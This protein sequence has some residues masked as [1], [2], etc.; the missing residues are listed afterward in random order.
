MMG[1]K[2]LAFV[3]VGL[4]VSG[5]TVN[6]LAQR[7]PVKGGPGPKP[8][9]WGD[10][11]WP[12]YSKVFGIEDRLAVEDVREITQSGGIFSDEIRPGSTCRVELGRAGRLTRCEVK[13]L[14]LT[15]IIRR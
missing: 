8:V 9:Q 3:A 2:F 14:G 10:P 7:P 15:V 13:T 4:L 12:S 1:R 11:D 5:L 6:A